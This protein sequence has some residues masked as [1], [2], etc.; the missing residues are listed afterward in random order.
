MTA[1]LLL[2]GPLIALSQQAPSP[3]ASG[4]EAFRQELRIRLPLLRPTPVLEALI[5]FRANAI[6]NDYHALGLHERDVIV[7]PGGP[8][9][10]NALQAKT[11]SE[12]FETLLA[13]GSRWRIRSPDGEFREIE[14][15]PLVPCPGVPRD[16]I[17]DGEI[18]FC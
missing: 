2:T 14:F 10:V 11:V 4:L 18:L 12:W 17:E 9:P 13:S 1:I 5:G 7:L 15:E 6:V 3:D 16:L 8:Y